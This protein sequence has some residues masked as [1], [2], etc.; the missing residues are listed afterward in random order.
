MHLRN[1]DDTT[2]SGSSNSVV[3]IGLKTAVLIVDPVILDI[4]EQHLLYT[5]MLEGFHKVMTNFHKIMEQYVCI[6]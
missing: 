2:V 5:F 3:Y 4:Q 1:Q 6:L